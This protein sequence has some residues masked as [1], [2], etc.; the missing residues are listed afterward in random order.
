MRLG[1]VIISPIVVVQP[2]TSIKDAALLLAEK[3][4]APYP[5]STTRA[6]LGMYSTRTSSTWRPILTAQSPVPHFPT[7]RRLR[8]HVSQTPVPR[9]QSVENLVSVVGELG[10]G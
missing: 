5:W 10:I 4:T 1:Q 2:D 8:G 6:S 3:R 9:H 7:P